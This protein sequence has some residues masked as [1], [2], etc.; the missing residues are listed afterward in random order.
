[1]DQYWKS[2]LLATLDLIPFVDVVY[3]P[4]MFFPFSRKFYPYEFSFIKS[5]RSVAFCIH[6]DF[7]CRLDPRLYEECKSTEQIVYSN[8]VFI[9]ACLKPPESLGWFYY[10]KER[11]FEYMLLREAVLV[12]SLGRNTTSY[13]SVKKNNNG[14]KVLVV[15]ASN[16]G[17]IG[18]DLIAKS[19]REQIYSTKL[20]CSIYLSDFNVS[21][22][23]IADYDL[24]IVGGGGIIYSSQ[25]GMNDT[26]NLSNYLKL[27]LWAKE[28]SIPCIIMGVGVQGESDQFTK[29]QYVCEFMN[30]SLSAASKI[31]VRDQLSKNVIGKFTN[32]YIN[33]LPDLVFSFASHFPYYKTKENNACSNVFMFVGELFSKKLEF[34][35]NLLKASAEH[36]FS[37][38]GGQDIR[39]CIMS[40]DDLVHKDVFVSLMTSKNIECKVHDLRG[41]TPDSVLTVFRE[42]SGV[43][44]TRFHGLVLSIIAGSPVLSIDL[45]YGKHALLIKDYFPSIKNNLIDETNSTNKILDK[46]GVLVEQP[47]SLLPD[48]CEIDAVSLA[49]IEY[50]N[51]IRDI[52]S[53]LTIKK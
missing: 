9:V 1:M 21:R 53:K 29:D 50:A 6:K 34:F 24:I 36:I 32:N 19:I 8:A 23:D 5:Q 20:E 45:S 41:L 44:T 11:Y 38:F 46:L 15:G 43:I 17:N 26:D 12:N 47:S 40:N 48:I 25:F 22:V 33:V 10:E 7:V 30:Q 4:S 16:M 27:P 37:I 3:T 35:N 18:D 42:A 52:L 51:T 2:A 14:F 39:Y 31:I 13:W 28:L 49:T